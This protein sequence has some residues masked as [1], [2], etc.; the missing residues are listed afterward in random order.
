MNEAIRKPY[1]IKLNYNSFLANFQQNVKIAPLLDISLPLI[2][3]VWFE[4][5]EDLIRLGLKGVIDS[6]AEFL[7]RIEPILIKILKHDFRHENHGYAQAGI[8]PVISTYSECLALSNLAQSL[9][10][11]MPLMI[12]VRGSNTLSFDRDS[13]DE[14]CARIPNLPMIDLHGLFFRF[15]P[16]KN[17]IIR[18]KR[19]LYDAGA[20]SNILI[21]PLNKLEQGNLDILPCSLWENFALDEETVGSFPI[22]IGFSAF[23]VKSDKSGCIFQADI[24]RRNG[25]PRNFPAQISGFDA[26]VLFVEDDFCELRVKEHIETPYPVSGYLTGGEAY[27]PIELR[28]WNIDEL[29]KLIIGLSDCPVYLDKS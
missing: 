6:S 29:K 25:L 22:E 23:P 27:H 15:S 26:E 14:L 28:Q 5:E 2:K 16:D 24:G 12:L 4:L 7:V 8:I 21:S 11:R 19:L 1:W 9:E 10:Q 20:V 3:S 18:W 17:S 13:I